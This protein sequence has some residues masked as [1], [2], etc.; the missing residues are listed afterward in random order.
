MELY[1]GRTRGSLSSSR[2]THG[3]EGVRCSRRRQP[4][5]RLSGPDRRLILAGAR[6]SGAVLRFGGTACVRLGQV[7]G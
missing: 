1:R 7:F 5:L 6:G 2:D 3:V 4:L